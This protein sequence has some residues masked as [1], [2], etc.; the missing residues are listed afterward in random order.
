MQNGTSTEG[1]WNQ[2]LAEAREEAAAAKEAY[3]RL[4]N[5][6][7]EEK[8]AQQFVL[9]EE[10]RSKALEQEI[11][12]L[13]KKIAETEA[14]IEEDKAAFEGVK[15]ARDK[16]LDEAAKWKAAHETAVRSLAQVEPVA[17]EAKEKHQALV[18]ARSQL[19]SLQDN[20]DELQR[21]VE[22]AQQQAKAAEDKCQVFY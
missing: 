10:G 1:E 5:F 16:A 19:Q 22:K 7:E 8:A 11:D 6:V 9:Q 13:R 12:G 21:E 18:A 15:S 17:Q 2:E 3:E 20:A 4:N 14:V